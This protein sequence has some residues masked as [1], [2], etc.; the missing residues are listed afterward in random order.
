MST[1]PSYMHVIQDKN[2]S[3]KKRTISSGLRALQ[4]GFGYSK[5]DF[6]SNSLFLL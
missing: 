6:A 2:K 5:A 1:C 3:F 4:E